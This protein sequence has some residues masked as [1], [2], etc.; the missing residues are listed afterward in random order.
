MTERN[1]P[2]KNRNVIIEGSGITRLFNRESYLYAFKAINKTDDVA[3]FEKL[4]RSNDYPQSLIKRAVRVI[5]R[6]DAYTLVFLNLV[7]SL[8]RPL[9][10]TGKRNFTI[11]TAISP[12]IMPATMPP[13]MSVQ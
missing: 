5:G 6:L 11:N 3:D 4:M 12:H 2:W 10:T 9:S 1:N 8:S 13:N 7:K